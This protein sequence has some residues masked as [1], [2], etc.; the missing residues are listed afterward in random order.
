MWIVDDR[1]IVIGADTEKYVS[2]TKYHQWTACH[3]PYSIPVLTVQDKCLAFIRILVG[4]LH[5]ILTRQ[6]LNY[7]NARFSLLLSASSVRFASR[8]QWPKFKNFI[9]EL[10]HDNYLQR[11]GSF[12]PPQP[13]SQL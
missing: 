2:Y 13:I 6:R 3:K 7:R 1:D 9:Q 4:N 8:V 5:I 11:N 12:P 10:R